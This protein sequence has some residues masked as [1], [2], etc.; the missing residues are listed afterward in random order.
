MPI[1]IT[2]LTSGL[3]TE[4]IISALVSSYNYKTNKY[5]KAQTKLSWKQ[6]AWKSLNTKIYSF[7]TSLDGLR[8]SKNYNL[9]STTCSDSTK[10]TVT[11][12]SNAVNGTQKVN[13]L[14]VAQ[15]G[16]LTGGQLGKNVTESTTLAELGYTD[17]DGTIN[18]T[19][20][21]GTTKSLTVSQGTTVQ[22]FIA[23]LKEAGVNASYDTTN[24]R[25][26]ISSKETGADNDF[27]ITGGNT[28][29]INALSKLGLS[30]DSDA[31]LN[32]YKMYAKYADGTTSDSEITDKVKKAIEEYNQALADKETATAQN[33]NLT[34]AYGYASA[35][36]KLQQALEKSGLSDDE[37]TQFTKLL[38]MSA[39]ER[40]KSVISDTGTVY[41]LASDMGDGTKYYKDDAG[42][43]I[44][45]VDTHTGSDG[46]TYLYDETTGTYSA[47]GKTYKVSSE[48]D[49]S[50]KSYYVNT[51]DANDKIT[52]DTTTEYYNA[53]AEE[54]TTDLNLVEVGG[55]SY[56]QSDTGY[57]TGTDGK[58]YRADE[59]N[60]QLIEVKYDSDSKIYT[61]VDGGNT[62]AYADDNVSKIKQTE[63][64][65]QDAR[66]DLK[67][68]SD[69][70]TALQ[71]KSKTSQSLS[72]DN[73]NS[74]LADIQTNLAMVNAFENASDDLDA[75]EDYTKAKI[76]ADIKDAYVKNGGVT[77]VN[78]LVNGYADIIST[79]TQTISDAEDTVKD[80]SAL[81]SIAAMKDGTDK[82][83]AISQF[84]EQVKTAKANLSTASSKATADAKKVD[85]QD[86]I[87]SVNGI[88]YQGS[89]NAFSINGLTITAQSVTGDGDANAITITTQTDVQ[90]IYDKVKSFLT[91][92]NSLINEITSLYN[93][94]SSKGYDPLTDDEKDAMSDS[95]IEKWETKIKD[96]LLRRDDTL[97]SV[98]NSMTSSMSK[99]FEINGKNY[100]LSTFGIKTLGYL[101]APENQQNAYHID[102][103]EDDASTSGKD[104]KLM[105]AITSDPD[106]V[107]TF[108]QQLADGLYSSLGDKMKS[109]TMSSVYTVYNDKEMASEYSDYT[110][111]IK[112]W[113]QKLQDQE[114]A[115]YK[116]FS[117][118]ETA[119]SKL[120]S[121]TSSL[122]NL[123]GG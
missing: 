20:G 90:G 44:Q 15:A 117:A 49:A 10:A 45:R 63:Y 120:Q 121:Q 119:L 93:A 86:A 107:I 31:T 97:Q 105:T 35:Y 99:G 39:S 33:A 54:K 3:D 100:Y 85:G 66:S 56:A 52:I 14:Q 113:E 24:R 81:A 112:K 65:K 111:T 46:K 18:L 74:Y 75:S 27:T 17:G 42:N 77:G 92:Y 116:K 21:D 84:V 62:V 94:E 71:E 109:T 25:F 108:M 9:K 115:Y 4:A 36:N 60:H 2:G 13:I 95:E 79:N 48:K 11:A 1:R 118:M 122:S 72:D 32:T 110:D 106:T 57:Y 19:K 55:A 64:K 50:G 80:N 76:A 59:A 61:D 98:M 6:D 78:A 53:T 16:Y 38:T 73:F 28:A 102:G 88:K 41:T 104:D 69:Q 70:L 8:F 22:Q 40:T 103:D 96:S 67:A 12:T 43:Y 47:N 26:Y 23:S 101:N 58:I 29:G 30:V 114:D 5:K 82:D 89:S 51:D 34:S 83:N 7:Y 123:F 68:S 91:Q 37:R 87:I